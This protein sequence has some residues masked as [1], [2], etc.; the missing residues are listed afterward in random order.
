ME[1]LRPP[2]GHRDEEAPPPP[3]NRFIR[4]VFAVLFL[5]I[6]AAV[7]FAGGVV[8]R[9]PE[10]PNYLL[11]R[12]V[13]GFHGAASGRTAT[14]KGVVSSAENLKPPPPPTTPEQYLNLMSYDENSLPSDERAVASVLNQT[15][16]HLEAASFAHASPELAHLFGAR[17]I[18]GLVKL[19]RATMLPKFALRSSNADLR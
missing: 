2:L 17:M 6:G 16:V 9:N 1:I 10:L 13:R 14:G 4:F 7:F 11:D 8:V 18:P 19:N 5:V 3:R 12:I 15:V